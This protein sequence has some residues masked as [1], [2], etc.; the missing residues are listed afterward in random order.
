MWRGFQ[1]MGCR[2]GE[3]GV[4]GVSSS[5]EINYY[6]CG[7]YFSLCLYVHERLLL[8]R[9]G[10]RAQSGREDSAAGI[11]PAECRILAKRNINGASSG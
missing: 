2:S 11:Q 10:R 4:S 5:S 6:L 3:G 8:R 7:L 9:R 1:N